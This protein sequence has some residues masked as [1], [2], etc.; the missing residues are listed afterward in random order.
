MNKNAPCDYSLFPVRP[1][2]YKCS[3]MYGLSDDDGWEEVGDSHIV[4]E[5]G[6]APKNDDGDI[7]D[8]EDD[9]VV[10]AGVPLPAPLVP[11]KAEVELHNLTHLPYRSWCPHCVASRRPNSHHKLSSR[12]SRRT[13]PLMVAD[14][15]YVR[16]HMDTA[17]VTVLVVRLKPSNLLMA[18]VCDEKGLDESVVT[19]LSQFIKA[20]GYARIAYRSDQEASLRALFEAAFVTSQRQGESYNAKLEQLVPEASSVGESQSNGLAENSVQ[21][22]EDLLRTY[23]SALETRV[24]IRIPNDSAVMRWLVEHAASV[25][26]RHLCNADGKTPF[27]EIHG[28]RWR[29]RQVE[30]GEQVFYFVPKRLRAKLNLR[31]R[32]GSF[33]GNAQSTNECYVA[34][35]NGDVVMTRAIVRVVEGNRWSKEAAEGVKG[36]PMKL[37]PKHISDS[38]AF[39]EESS[40][41]HVSDDQTGDGDDVALNPADVKKIDKQLRISMKDLQE[42]GFTEKCGRCSDLQAGVFKTKRLHTT[43]C[44]MRLYLAFKDHDHP[45]WKQVKHLFEEPIDQPVHKNNID[46]EGSPSTPRADLQAPLFEDTVPNV[47]PDD[48][49]DTG[50]DAESLLADEAAAVAFRD[51]DNSKQIHNSDEM[52]VAELFFDSDDGEMMDPIAEAD[53]NAMVDA[54]RIAGVQEAKATEFA[55]YVCSMRPPSTFMEIYGRSISDYAGAHRRNLNVSGLGALDLRTLKPDGQTWNFCK[56]SDCKLA[57]L[58]QLKILTG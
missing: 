50:Q 38:D 5:G 28:Q 41:P 10:Q 4:A 20:S 18:T 1:L 19:R 32:V 51:E 47:A 7:V 6:R 46:P 17:V 33:M 25:F 39:I 12:S 24:G 26:N 27:E 16:D 35:G 37:R 36:T 22:I 53:E 11:S 45:K 40:A 23:K 48:G 30:F 55:K 52:E 57:N 34:A 58:W 49:V 8:L 54:L 21:R 9:D 44:R 3:P 42:F 15:A 31:W 14:Y 2:H 29:G 56:R 43:D 13:I